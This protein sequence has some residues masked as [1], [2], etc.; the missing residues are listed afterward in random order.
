M[1]P[2]PQRPPSFWQACPPVATDTSQTHGFL[3]GLPTPLPLALPNTTATSIFLPGLPT[4]C[5]LYL[6]TPQLPSSSCWGYPP[7][8]TLHL[9]TPQLPARATHSWPTVPP[10]TTATSIFLPGLPTHRHFCTSQHHSYLPGLPTHGQHYHPTPQL[11]PSSCRGYPP[12]AT[13]APPST[14]STFQGYPLMANITTQHHSYLHLPAGATHPS[15]LAPPNTTATFL[16]RSEC[17]QDL[18]L[19]L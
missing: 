10:N 16:T 15:P 4:H 14:T 7:I 9:P 6:P 12:I 17:R 19:P 3:T 18:Q 1:F 11:P 8:A 13:F 5:H 2:K